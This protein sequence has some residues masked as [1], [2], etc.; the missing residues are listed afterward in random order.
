MIRWMKKCFHKFF[1]N[2]NGAV[3]IYAIMITLLLFIFNGVLIDFI[4]IMAAERETDQAMKAAVRSTMS[5]YNQDV[6]GYGLFGFDG[7]Q[8]EANEIFEKVFR[9][10]LKQ[11]DGDYFRFID[12]KPEGDIKTIIKDERM[13][14]NKTT[15]EYQILEEMKYIAPMEVGQ[16]IIEGFLQVSKG[17]QEASAYV[18]IATSI[19]DDVDDREESLDKIKL[20]LEIAKQRSN[21]LGKY[22]NNPSEAS[23]P[24]VKNLNDLL[25]HLTTYKEIKEREEQPPAGEDE[26][27]EEKEKREEEDEKR[28]EDEKKVKTYEKQVREL[29]EDF[30]LKSN[31]MREELKEILKLVEKADKLNDQI[32][33]TIEDKRNE[34]KGTYNKSNQAADMSKK[35]TGTANAAIDDLEEA[36]KKLDDYIIDPKFFEDLKNKVET[37]LTEVDENNTTNLA[38]YITQFKSTVKKDNFYKSS[39][40]IRTL[41]EKIQSH[42]KTANTLIDDALKIMTGDRPEIKDDEVKEKEKE[43]EEELD[44][45]NEQ[46]DKALD[47]AN[48]YANDNA[49]LGEIAELAKKYQGSIESS[50]NEF[51]RENPDKVAKDAMNF[52]D[53]VFSAV[54]DALI[55]SRDKIYVNEY[56]LTKF[57]SHDFNKKGV[58]GFALENNQVEY[59]MYGLESTGANYGAAMTELFAFRF[60]VNFLEAFTKQY[61]RSF[62][63]WMW[64]AALVYALEETIV[65]LKNINDGK[66]IR[67]FEPM[68]F[69]TSYFDYLRIFL[70][71]HPEGNKMARTMALIENDTGADLTTLP[72]Y[73]SGEATTS[74]KLWFLPGVTKM[75]GKTGVITGKVENNRYFIDKKIDYSY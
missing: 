64:A 41:S 4:R 55:D 69:T 42:Q 59:I 11:E 6:K 16:T 27:D 8:S 30:E 22:V 46:L 58:E 65:D 12:T 23:F 10:N 25:K 72:T 52:V 40:T 13:L 35:G 20:K 17:M 53:K 31:A 39:S 32:T 24:T 51:N 50:K 67:F 3:S 14:S 38:G 62:G 49:L 28:K 1:I 48:K 33:E 60:A 7:G 18:D 37:A 61:V 70:F 74:V 54:G 9:E 45:L 21:E 19:Q 47:E 2:E 71:M 63:P 75:L 66:S 73:I 68:R 43:S 29:A 15:I 5:A 34:A 44:N 36:N 26:T 57:K 56:I